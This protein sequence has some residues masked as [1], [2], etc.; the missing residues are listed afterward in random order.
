MLFSQI[1]INQV[2]LFIVVVVVVVFSLG[3]GLKVRQCYAISKTS[4][5]TPTEMFE[6]KKN[7]RLSIIFLCRKSNFLPIDTK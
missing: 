4:E 5:I 6:C 7:V 2:C 1:R 3:G